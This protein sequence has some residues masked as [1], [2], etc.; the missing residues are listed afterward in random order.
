MAATQGVAVSADDA[1][2]HL[3]SLIR[4]LFGDGASVG[5]LVRH[6]ATE[7]GDSITPD[8]GTFGQN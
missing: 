3:A 2:L 8:F 1:Q 5:T 7:V 4:C 6:R